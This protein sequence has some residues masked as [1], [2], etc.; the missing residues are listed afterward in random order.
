MTYDPLVFAAHIESWSEEQ[1][2][3][4]D[5]IVAGSANDVYELA[6]RR[7]P[8]VKQTGGSYREG[9]VA[10]DTGELIGSQLLVLNGSV[11]GRGPVAYEGIL[12]QMRAGDISDLIFTAPHARHHEYG[13]TGKFGGRFYVRNAVQ[14]WDRIVEANADLYSD[15]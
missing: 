2:E 3:N 5:K 6:T 7:Q 8:S 9:F 15:S 4:T 11:I 10:V 1:I 13:V 14:Q 12:A